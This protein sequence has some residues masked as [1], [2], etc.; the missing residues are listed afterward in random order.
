MKKTCFKCGRE[1]PLSEFYTHPEMADGHLNKCKSCTR[2]DVRETRRQ[3]ADYYATYEA[4]RND[5]PVR[6]AR[7][8]ERLRRL[9]RSPE[10]KWKRR[11]RNRTLRLIRKGV[12]RRPERCQA[13]GSSDR[14]PE[15]HHLT[16]DNSRAVVFLCQ[17]CHRDAH[18]GRLDPEPLLQRWV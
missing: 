5:D 17:R 12:I 18:Y 4:K 9:D 14:V 8:R 6:R 16:Y 13:C 10:G 11:A 15:A 2:R 1:L 3:R 7:K